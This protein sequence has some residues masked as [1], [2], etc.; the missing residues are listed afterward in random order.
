[1]TVTEVVKHIRRVSPQVRLLHAIWN[2]PPKCDLSNMETVAS[3]PAT[4]A[5]RE[6]AGI[7]HVGCRATRGA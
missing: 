7:G 3:V 6:F 5:A 4:L 1:M 2:V